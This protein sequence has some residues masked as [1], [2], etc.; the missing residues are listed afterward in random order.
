MFRHYISVCRRLRR[1]LEAPLLP[2]GEQTC[3]I[4]VFWVSGFYSCHSWRKVLVSWGD[5]SFNHSPYPVSVLCLL[6]QHGVGAPAHSRQVMHLD[7]MVSWTSMVWFKAIT[8]LAFNIWFFACFLLSPG[9]S[10]CPFFFSF[11]SP[12]LTFLCSAIYLNLF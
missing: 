8:P 6:S 9:S 10:L 1:I 11:L 7:L 5:F 3:F 12:L 2:S 4:D